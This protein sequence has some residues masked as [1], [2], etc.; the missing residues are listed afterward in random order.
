M[1]AGFCWRAWA[2]AAMVLSVAAVPTG[3]ATITTIAKFDG[4]QRN[5]SA[6]LIADGSGNL[7]GTT[8]GGPGASANY[9][10]VF[11]LDASNNYA[12]SALTSFNFSNGGYP[13]GGLIADASGNLYGTTTVSHVGY[14]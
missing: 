4:S 14:G 12:L 2:F 1:R 9:G 11:K 5:P 6:P 10:S 3:G 8:T 7:Y 13:H